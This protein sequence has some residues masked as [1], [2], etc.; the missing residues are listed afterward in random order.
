MWRGRAAARSRTSRYASP[1]T[2]ARHSPWGSRARSASR[3]PTAAALAG[4]ELHAGDGGFVDD[5]G[6]LH[7][8]DRKSLV[9]IRGGA[10]VYPAEVERVLLEAPGV[11]A[12]AV[13]GVPDERLGERVVAVLEAGAL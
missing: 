8:R 1:T 7:L 5:E 10:N 12:A 9:I 4:D 6:Y 3:R 2:T 13:F 11:T